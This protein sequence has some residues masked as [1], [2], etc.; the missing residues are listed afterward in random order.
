MKADG[1][2]TA[3]LRDGFAPEHRMVLFDKIGSEPIFC[4]WC[5]EALQWNDCVADHLNEAP[6]D[7]RAENIVPSCNT[8]NL[9]RGKEKS[10][11][12]RIARHGKWYTING[13]RRHIGGW[14]EIAGITTAVVRQRIKMGWPEEKALTTPAR[15]YR[16]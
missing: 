10:R 7:N 13:T 11:A 3:R 9:K 12:T 4:H 1:H 14:A 2:P 5:D 6:S 16:K 15:T 8:C